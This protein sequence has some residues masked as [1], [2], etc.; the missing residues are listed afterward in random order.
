MQLSSIGSLGYLRSFLQ[1]ECNWFLIHKKKFFHEYRCVATSSPIFTFDKFKDCLHCNII[2]LKRNSDFVFSLAINGIHAGQ[3]MT[4]SMKLKKRIV[5]N[6]LLYYVLEIGPLTKIDLNFVPKY[7]SELI[8][9][10]KDVTPNTI[11]ENSSIVSYSEAQLLTL[12]GA[13]ENKL[14]PLGCGSWCLNNIDNYYIYTFVLNYDLYLACFDN[15][16]PSLSKIIFDM[17]ACNNERCVFCKDHKKHVDSTGKTIGCIDNQETCFCYIPCR[18]KGVAI[19]NS[20]LSSLLCDQEIDTVDLMYPEKNAQ[21]STDINSF[22]TGYKNKEPIVLRNS[23]WIL[24]RLNP[25]L[26]RLI[27]LSCPVCKRIVCK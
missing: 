3:F 22:V 8:L 15:V 6:D 23:N 4:N 14:I 20:E 21:L 16:L 27:L 24:I 19:S 2:I 17:T 25:A 1:N 12:K 26:S 13:G 7:S 5:T 18:K 10:C 11:Y 9:E